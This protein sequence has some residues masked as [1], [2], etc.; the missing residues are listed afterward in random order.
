[1]ELIKLRRLRKNYMHTKTMQVVARIFI[2]NIGMYTCTALCTLAGAVPGSY[3]GTLPG[4]RNKHE[5]ANVRILL[6]QKGNIS[7]Y[8]R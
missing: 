5:Q 1:M 7:L 8:R 3:P 6:L 4:N 2:M